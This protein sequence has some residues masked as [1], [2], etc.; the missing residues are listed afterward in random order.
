[1]QI[2]P[3]GGSPLASTPTFYGTSV[4]RTATQSILAGTATLISW[5]AAVYDTTGAW[6]AGSPFPSRVLVLTTGYY[7]VRLCV[8]WPS[9]ADQTYR[10]VYICKNSAGNPATAAIAYNGIPALVA[11]GV[12]TIN[13]CSNVVALTAGDY[14]EGFC[15]QGS[16]GALAIGADNISSLS[17]AIL[18]T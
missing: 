4:K 2:G 9:G 5:Q 16:A 18:G 3:A 12:Y 13:E 10:N 6:F 17:V 7:L 1:M 11:L 15:V 8:I 14:V